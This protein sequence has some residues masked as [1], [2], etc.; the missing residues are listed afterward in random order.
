MKLKKIL[1]EVEGKFSKG[2]KMWIVDI[3]ND[4]PSRPMKASLGNI[5]KFNL[6]YIS[7]IS[8]KKDYLKNGIK[9][10]QNYKDV[11]KFKDLDAVFV[12]LPNYLAPIVTK[13]ALKNK[14]HVF[15]E[16]PPAKCSKETV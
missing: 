2:E 12:T 4:N 16:K 6:K 9:Y 1:N 11:F 3:I 13:D 14:L 8:F 5:Q 15:C 10:F 7:D